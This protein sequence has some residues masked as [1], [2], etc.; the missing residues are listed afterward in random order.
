MITHS[1]RAYSGLALLTIALLLYVHTQIMIF[2]VS[3]NIQSKE[4]QLVELGDELKA[5]Q[6]AVS[7]LHSLSYLEKRKEEANLKLVL[8]KTVKVIPIPMTKSV[9]HPIEAPAVVKRGIF[10]FVNFIKEAQAKT[11]QS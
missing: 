1:K 6:Y 2:Q 5:H 11:A 3:Y 10:S 9:D 8:P 4:K 7:Q